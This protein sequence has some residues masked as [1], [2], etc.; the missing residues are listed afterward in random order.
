MSPKNQPDD[1]VLL[2][3]DERRYRMLITEALRLHGYDI[4]EADSGQ[5]ALEMAMERRFDLVLLDVMLPDMDG[6]AVCQRL[7][8]FTSAPI[9]MVTARAEDQDK[10]RGLDVGADDYLTKPFSVEELLARVRA[11]LR[12]S[13]LQSSSTSLLRFGNL[14]IDGEA[15]RVMVGSGEIFLSPTEYRLLWFMAT[16]AGRVLLPQ[17]IAENVWGASPESLGGALKTT[18][19]RLRAKLEDDANTPKYI[20]TR[21]GIGYLFCGDPIQGEQ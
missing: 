7:R 19:W 14:T 3:E 10:V 18:I 11:V 4:L 21:K 20:R 16:N 2:V 6:F 17:T 5:A 9:I 8:E 13:R 1:T 15:H 12:R